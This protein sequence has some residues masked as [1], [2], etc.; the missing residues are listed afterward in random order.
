MTGSIQ[1]NLSTG[2]G[3]YINQFPEF[4]TGPVSYEDAISEE[5]FAKE[6]EALF[7]NSW[8]MVGRIEQ[9]PRGGSYFTRELP[10]LASLVITKDLAGEVHA[11]HNVC[12]HRGNKVVWQDHPAAECAGNARAFNCKYHGWRYDLEGK[13]DHVTN[14]EHFYDLPKSL[15]RMPKVACEVFAGFV[16]INLSKDPQPIDEF[17]GDRL[18][19]LEAY[20]FEKMTQRYGFKTDIKGNW[21]IAVDS[22]SEW[23]H[24]PYVH[25]RF[26]DTN[27]ANAEKLVPPIDA[28]HYDFFGRHM[29]TSVPGPRPLKPREIGN[30]GPLPR[31]QKE[32]YRRFRAGLFGPDDVPDIGGRPEFLNPGDIKYWS[33]DQYWFWPNL[34]VQIWER[35]YYITYQYWP[36]SVDE[37][38]YEVEMYFVP[39]TNALERLAQE[40]TV[41]STI[42]FF[43]QDINTME[44]THSAVRQRQIETFYLS[45]Q[46]IMIRALH[47]NVRDA[48]EEWEA[49]Q[50]GATA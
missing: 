10:N 6:K 43:F 19:A 37:M 49:K 18:K 39:P 14:E 40:L 23:Y 32:V 42:E 27:T 1:D 35:N 50:S 5:F 38:V 26:L 17:L 4:G 7:K 2:R 21:K 11:F 33:N 46:E 9:L 12:A 13:V 24:P 45:D 15:L 44:A 20:P 16:F 48:V 47:K 8:L 30:A 36:T 28:Y 3:L 41:D 31:D 29:M 22:V 34:Y 25:G